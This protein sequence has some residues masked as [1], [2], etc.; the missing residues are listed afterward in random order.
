MKPELPL[1]F[2]CAVVLALLVTPAAIGQQGS[3]LGFGLSSEQSFGP[4]SDGP[5]KG[6][7]GGFGV[8]YAFKGGASGAGPAA[9][10]IQDPAGNLYGTTSQGGDLSCPDNPNVGCGVVFRLDTR[11]R[12][13]VLH[14]F[15]GGAS[16]GATPYGRLVMD[17]SGNLYGTTSSG[18]AFG[19]GTV[20]KI[21]PSGTETVLYSFSGGIDGANP[22]AGLVMDGAD[23][24]YGTTENGGASNSGTI[25]KIDAGGNENV[26]YTFKGGTSD[27]ADPKAGLT[28]DPAGNLY[29]TT[30]SG[31]SGGYGT[32]FELNTSGAETVIYNFTGGADGGNPF[33]GVTRDS[34]G[35]LYGT[36]ENG[37]SHSPVGRGGPVPD[38]HYGCCK[39]SLYALDGDNF[40]VM[41]TFTGGNDGGSPASDLVLSAGVLYGT[42]LV[43]GPGHR[44]TA[45]SLTI[46]TR[47]ESVLHGFTGKADGGTPQAGLLMNGAGVLY[48]TAEGGGRNQKG[49]VFQYKLK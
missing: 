30:F 29:G 16:D 17:G 26:L 4:E 24:L 14:A 38:G 21:D 46:S 6:G 48:G 27:G 10:L 39:G 32:V 2:F 9:A 49:T 33:G 37:G 15:A 31:G 3:R 11:N 47:S 40:S 20:F 22:Y 36:A 18:G 23:D 19:L 41:Y 34:T 7:G 43:G 42:T 45:F 28:F 5:G 13:K 1:S 44:G 8:D 25:F 35:V 12:E